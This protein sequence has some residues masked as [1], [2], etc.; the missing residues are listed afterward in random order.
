M[1][2]FISILSVIAIV[3]FVASLYLFLNQERILFHPKHFPR[4]FEYCYDWE[5]EEFFLSPEPG[6]ELNA[7]RI[8]K[9]NS[10]GAILYL[11][12]N[13]GHLGKSGSFYNRVKDFG[14]DVILYDYRNYGKSNGILSYKSLLSDGRFIFNWIAEQYGEENIIVHGSSLGSGIASFIA[15][16]FNPKKLVL[17]TPYYSIIKTAR[18]KY[19]YAPVKFLNK[20]PLSNARFLP[21][22]Q[23]ESH[24]IHGTMDKTVPYAAARALKSL[25]PKAQLHT[26]EGGGHSNLKEFDEYH[27]VLKD[28][29]A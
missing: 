25:C 14:Y 29:Y 1:T 4:D 23:C 13:R 17:E 5:F 21:R 15:S 20:F 11:H 19:P 28:I 18:Y 7:M 6:I 8:K 16:Q 2:I 22:V 24:I 12:G 3:Y 27:K 26:I 9:P 10:R